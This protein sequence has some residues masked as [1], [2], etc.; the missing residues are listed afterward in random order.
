MYLILLP[1]F[2]I[3]LYAIYDFW[4]CVKQSEVG[5][6]FAIDSAKMDYDWDKNPKVIAIILID[7]T[8]IY[9]PIV[10]G[11]DNKKY[12]TRDINDNFSVAGSI[13]LDYRNSRDFSDNYNIIYGHRMSYGQ[14]FSDIALFEDRNYFD[15]RRTA[16][17]LRADEEIKLEVIAFVRISVSSSL[18]RLE[19]RKFRADNLSDIRNK[20]IHYRANDERGRLF[21][22]ST[23]NRSSK[24]LRDILV[25]KECS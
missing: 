23:C 21:I 1:I 24:S 9:Y 25:L 3:S 22:L 5:E 16:T 4:C 10:Q 7:D 8:T 14:M 13:F 6:N 20:A 11:R 17:I 12:L 2:L 18:Y 15:A 19:S